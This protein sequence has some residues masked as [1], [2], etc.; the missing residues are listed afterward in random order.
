MAHAGLT[1]LYVNLVVYIVNHFG[2]VSYYNKKIFILLDPLSQVGSR[3]L[4]GLP[5]FFKRFQRL[6]SFND[7]SKRSQSRRMLFFV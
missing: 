3:F 6:N 7:S 4:N 1:L 2:L 5:Q